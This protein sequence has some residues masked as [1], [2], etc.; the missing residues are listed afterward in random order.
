MGAGADVA[1]TPV[2]RVLAAGAPAGARF[3]GV[4]HQRSPLAAFVALGSPLRHPADLAGARVAASTIPWFDHEYRAGLEVL[5]LAPGPV[6]PAHA[7][8]TRPSLVA[9][10]VDVIGSWAESRAVLRRRATVPVRSIAFGPPVYTMGLLAADS[11]APELVARLVAG[12][13]EAYL[14]QRRHPDAGLAE[15]CRR[16]PRVAPADALEEWA[17]LDPYLFGDAPPLS[18]DADR[19]HDTLAHA[20]RAHGFPPP[21]LD[22]VCRPELLRPTPAL[23]SK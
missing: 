7:D 14:Q 2:Y 18:M 13:A 11:L 6:V 17:L 19:W 12:L 16:F 3:V 9:G 20:T 10:E 15:L 21:A 5:G 8:G 4:V 22:E 1:V 23:W